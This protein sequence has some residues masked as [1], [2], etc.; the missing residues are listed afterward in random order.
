M[1]GRVFQAGGAIPP[2]SPT[3]VERQA[4]GLAL[5]RVQQMEY[6]HIVVARQMGK[7]CLLYRLASRLP[8]DQYQ[9]VWVDLAG[10]AGLEMP[11]WYEA[12]GEEIGRR[13]TPVSIPHLS[14]QKDLQD[15]LLS[16]MQAVA[17]AHNVVIILDEI[18]STRGLHFSDGFFSALRT[19]YNRRVEEPC[20]RHLAFVMVGAT[21]PR[22]LIKDPNL[23]PFNVGEEVRLEE[24]TAEETRRLT[25]NLSLAA[26]ETDEATHE[27]IYWWTS[28]QPYLTQRVCATLEDWR[29]LRGLRQATPE[30]LDQAVEEAILRP[31][32]N[33]SNI[34]H[35]KARLELAPGARAY[36]QRI[37]AGQ[38]IPF[39]PNGAVNGRL[40]ELHLIG[41]VKEGPEGNTVVR[42][43]I[44]EKTV[45]D[46][47]R[48]ASEVEKASLRTRWKSTVGICAIWR[49]ERPCTGWKCL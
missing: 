12:V 37:F 7:T 14:D 49:S 20:L 9:P 31:A 2:D 16:A 43:R 30:L 24:F 3:Y 4:D 18:D 1:S 41:V 48:L 40:A 33:D 26:I 47:V 35:V 44:Y 46:Y 5:L 13:L 21:D 11:R 27:R 42:N 45:S 32:A 10:M 15:Y 17:G 8:P 6:V 19:L 34:A 25:D 36:L 23:S 39:E 29:G 22:R 38:M 28:G